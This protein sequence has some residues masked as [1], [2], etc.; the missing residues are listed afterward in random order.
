MSMDTQWRDI[1]KEHPCAPW[2]AQENNPCIP[3]GKDWRKEKE[4]H[5]KVL[6]VKGK[7]KEKESHR[8][9]QKEKEKENQFESEVQMEDFYL[10]PW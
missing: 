3:D 4:N 5:H 7:E 10:Q 6:R 2:Y 1:D 8:W 9:V